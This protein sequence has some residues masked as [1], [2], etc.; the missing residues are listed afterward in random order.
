MSIAHSLNFLL[1]SGVNTKDSSVRLRFVDVTIL[2]SGY[3]T[4][5]VHTIN[6]VKLG[7]GD[8]RPYDNWGMERVAL[9]TVV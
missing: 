9:S 8:T 7:I 1:E 3:V 6:F 4:Y 2:S 5:A